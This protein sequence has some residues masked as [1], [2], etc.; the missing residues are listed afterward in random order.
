MD[1]AAFTLRAR[2]TAALRAGRRAAY[3]AAPTTARFWA[4]YRAVA[5]YNAVPSPA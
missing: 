1:Y 3:Y 5:L 2:R 4:Y